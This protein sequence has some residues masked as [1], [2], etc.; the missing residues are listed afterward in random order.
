M[1][2]LVFVSNRFPVLSPGK[3]KPTTA[4]L[5]FKVFQVLL[6]H[7]GSLARFCIS[8]V[9]S[10]LPRSAF[11]GFPSLKTLNLQ[12]TIILEADLNYLILKCPLLEKLTAKDCIG[13]GH[14]ELD[15]PNLKVICFEASYNVSAWLKNTPL[16]QNFT[17][18]HKKSCSVSQHLARDGRQ[19]DMLPVMLNHLVILELTL[20]LHSKCETSWVLHLIRRC[21]NLKSLYFKVIRADKPNVITAPVL[22]LLKA[23]AHS[24]Y[25]LGK[26]SE[27]T[28][29]F[30]DDTVEVLEFV[31]LLLA[32]SRYEFVYV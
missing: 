29:E 32:K 31:K 9:L 23:Q 20:C 2:S 3:P 7:K 21:P 19:A 8:C 15:A 4:E 24:E 6:P 11:G 12:S 1:S 16:L 18:Y 10:P 17:S 14:L 5:L 28:L 13:L 27:I 30:S 25:S 22:D 26:L